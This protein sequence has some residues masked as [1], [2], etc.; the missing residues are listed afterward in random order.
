[1]QREP[2]S[3]RCVAHIAL[4]KLYYYDK[5]GKPARSEPSLAP[6]AARSRRSDVFVLVSPVCRISAAHCTWFRRCVV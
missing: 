4:G 5:Q 3:A 1:M 2:L 6:R